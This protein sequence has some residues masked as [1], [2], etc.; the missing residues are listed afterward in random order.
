MLGKDDQKVYLPC[1]RIP[2]LIL[3]FSLSI[4]SHARLFGNVPNEPPP[5]LH[6]Q[7][8]QQPQQQQQHPHRHLPFQNQQQPQRGG[9]FF[10]GADRQ[11]RPRG[12]PVVCLYLLAIKFM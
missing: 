9:L 2:L 11:E 5:H 1:V 12:G 6:H 4:S 7:N 3:I 8:Q 10:G